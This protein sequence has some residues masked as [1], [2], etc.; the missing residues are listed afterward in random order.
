M[1]SFVV[2]HYLNEGSGD[3][4]TGQVSAMSDEASSSKTLMDC[5]LDVVFGLELPMGSRE[6]FV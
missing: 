6:C 2:K 4:W 3:P 1:E 5:V